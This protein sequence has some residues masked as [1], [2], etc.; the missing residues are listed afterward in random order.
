MFTKVK[1]PTGVMLAKAGRGVYGQN[2]FDGVAAPQFVLD[3]GRLVRDGSK[4][5]MDDPM[6]AVVSRSKSHG[7]IRA[8]RR[9]RQPMRPAIGVFVDALQLRRFDTHRQLMMHCILRRNV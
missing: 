7:R 1:R 5:R 3:Q 6:H 9:W 8:R 2:R 4:A